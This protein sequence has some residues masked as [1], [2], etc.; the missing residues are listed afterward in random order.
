MLRAIGQTERTPHP[1]RPGLGSTVALA[2][3]S[4]ISVA[5]S[6]RD[7]LSSRHVI[8]TTRARPRGMVAGV[9]F[10]SS[11]PYRPH[12]RRDDGRHAHGAHDQVDDQLAVSS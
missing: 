8:V 7:D 6:D 4:A 10:C 9:T 11:R 2:V 12:D 3:A 5:L 1:A